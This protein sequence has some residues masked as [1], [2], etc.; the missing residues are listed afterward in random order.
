MA[1]PAAQPPRK[2]KVWPWVLGG[3]LLACALGIGGCAALIGGSAVAISN[4]ADEAIQSSEAKEAA[5]AAE[6]TMTSCAGDGTWFEATGVAANGSSERS[7][8]FIE[9][10][11]LDATG[12]NLDTG[13]ATA[14]NVEPGQ[15]A[16]WSATAFA[17]AAAGTV[18]C[19]VADVSRTASL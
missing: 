2:K 5:A 14:L 16:T 9:V 7:D 1:P 6:V 11:F 18:E 12:V 19:N 4:A 13:F 10:T 8:Y 15:T 3:F 17:A